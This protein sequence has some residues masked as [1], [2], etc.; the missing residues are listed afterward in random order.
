M[1]RAILLVSRMLLTRQ[2]LNDVRQLLGDGRAAELARIEISSVS[3]GAA[4]ELACYGWEL[5]QRE[6]PLVDA[7]FLVEIRHRFP[8]LARAHSLLRDPGTRGSVEPFAS[9]EIE[10]HAVHGGS[11]QSSDWP[12]FFQ[13]F[14]RTLRRQGFGARFADAFAGAFGEMADNVVQHGAERGQPARCRLAEAI[15][16]PVPKS[17]TG[18]PVRPCAPA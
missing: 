13:R 18:V 12:L 10:L 16:R 14:S 6:S 4:L 5:Q 17:K 11:L 15:A 8:L 1:I 3:L 2:D 9:P 7:G